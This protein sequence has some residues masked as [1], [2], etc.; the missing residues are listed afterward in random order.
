MRR[1]VAAG[2]RLR[3]RQDDDGEAHHA[4][5]SDRHGA[6]PRAGTSA[7]AQYYQDD[8]G[9]RPRRAPPPDYY[10]DRPRYGTAAVTGTS[11]TTALGASARI[12]VT[13]RG[14]CPSRPAPF[15]TP[16]GCEIPASA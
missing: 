4:G 10:D 2:M 7:G 8:E 15:N 3:T 5:G 11:T 9:Y 1:T 6:R 13:A 16:C 14:N 12:C